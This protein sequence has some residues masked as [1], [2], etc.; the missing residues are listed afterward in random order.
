MYICNDKPIL[1]NMKKA[2]FYNLMLVTLFWTSSSIMAQPNAAREQN[3]DTK[4]ISVDNNGQNI[5]GMAFLPKN[6]AAKM[7]LIICSHGFNGTYTSAMPYAESFTQQGYAIYAFDFRGG[8]GR[9]KSDGSSTDM[10]I[11]SEEDDLEA[12]LQAAKGWDFVDTKN[13][14][15]MGISQG[16]MISAMVGA[17][18]ESDVAGLLLI[19]PALCIQDDN[20]SRYPNFADVPDVMQFMGLNIGKAY[21]AGFENFDTYQYI[22]GF[23]K[24]VLIVH[25]D[26]DQLV[27][28]SYSRKAVETYKSAELKVIPGA[29]HGFR[30]EDNN[31]AIGYL[32]E[33]LKK[34]VATR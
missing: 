23:K 24:D 8:S 20:K 10:S 31:T 26:N 6:A 19:Y 29:G 28:I 30:G 17:H 27:N 14:F 34:H 18:H 4:E 21:Y 32:L 2:I 9:S 1:K 3:F 7:P 25:G 5:Y 13:I 11:F 16:G 22:G 15:L 12:V 33:Y